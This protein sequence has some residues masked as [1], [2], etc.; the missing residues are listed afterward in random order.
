MLIDGKEW[1]LVPVE[2]TDEML[3]AAARASLK[4]LVE[5]INDPAKA[6]ELGSEASVRKTHGSR[7]KSMLAAAPTP[8][9]A[10]AAPSDEELVKF[11]AEDEFLLFCD[12]DEFV[13]IARAV[14]ERYGQ[15]TSHE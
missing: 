4:R 12:E 7:Y 5:C 1:R 15:G 13:Q 2:P 9:A 10:T 6:D 11:A 8:P 14:L 3:D